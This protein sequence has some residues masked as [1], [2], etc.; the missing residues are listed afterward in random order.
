V[1]LGILSGWK[2]D[3]EA[4]NVDHVT[5][6]LVHWIVCGSYVILS[7][8]LYELHWSAAGTTGEVLHV[9]ISLVHVILVSYSIPWEARAI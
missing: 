9:Y 8:P 5:C 7:D 1:P 2:L 3:R 4:I 6:S